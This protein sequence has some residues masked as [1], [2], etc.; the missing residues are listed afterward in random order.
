MSSKN[1][2]N[3]D[4]NIVEELNPYGISVGA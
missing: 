4:P 3:P 1:P 2:L